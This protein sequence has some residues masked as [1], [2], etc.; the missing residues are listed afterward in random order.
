MTDGESGGDRFSRREVLRSCAVAAAAGASARAEQA[1]SQASGPAGDDLTLPTNLLGKTGVKV[2]RLAMGA[3][4]PSYHARLLDQA[5]RRGVRFFANAYSYGNGQ[6]E[7]ILGGWL[8]GSKRRPDSFIATHDGLTSPE[9]F[10]DKVVR[11]IK[12]LQVDTIDL[13]NIHAVQDPA[14]VADQGGYWRRLKDRL[15]REKKIRFM[16]FSTH[17]EMPARVGCLN[18]AARSGWV[19][20]VLVACDPLLLRTSADLNRA[21][22]ACA[23]ANVGLVAMKTTRGLGRKAAE[24]RGLKEGEAQ[25]E[26]MP[27]FEGL[28]LSAF[29]AIHY[30]MWSD[31]RFAAVCSAMLTR[32]MI[33]ENTRNARQFRKPL[34]EGQ[35]RLLEEGMKKLARS[36]CPGC[37]GSCR[38]AGHT[39]TDFCSIARYVAYCLED[40]SREL[41]RRLY[42]E[43]KP[44]QRYWEGAD[45]EAA[46]RACSARLDFAAM[47]EDARR[48][49]ERGGGDCPLL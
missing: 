17:A 31:G 36:T 8:R 6:Q 12:N 43:L 15:V 7:Q 9:L 25:T 46:S 21:I 42:A 44:A 10:H 45:L 23:K 1:A 47:L 34:D 11:A 28:G 24:R 3:G 39:E 13:M 37:D 40:G 26:A 33:D 41:A 22:D 30:G 16:G 35:R 49:L 38:R 5:Y 14:V 32:A 29:G 19:D 20:V 4:Y 2:T 48:W 27:G 18:A